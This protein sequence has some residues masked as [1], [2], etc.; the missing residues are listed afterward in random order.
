MTIELFTLCDG[1]YNYNGKLTIVGSW[2]SIGVNEIPSK[3]PVGVAMRI[4]I[5][6]GEKGSKEMKIQFLNPD[7]STIPTDIVA[8]LDI[9]QSKEIAYINLAATIQGFP[10]SQI[11]RHTVKVII[12]ENLIAEYPL[13]VEAKKA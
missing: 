9:K 2:T 13:V 11:G 3:I 4:R 1:A 6:V 5:E 7:G 10:I 8:S 12:D